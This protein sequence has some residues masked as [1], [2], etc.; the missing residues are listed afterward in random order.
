MSHNGTLSRVEPARLP[1]RRRA[2]ALVGRDLELGLIAAF[3]DRAAAEGGA[4]L[5]SGEPGV[6]KTALLDAAVSAALA[7]GAVVLRADG[8]DDET[9]IG[10][11][12][13][14]QALQPLR[15]ELESLSA[16]HRDALRAPLG[17]GDGPAP[18]RLVVSTAVLALLRQAGAAQPLLVVLDDLPW[19]DRAS[20]AVLGFAARRLAGSRVG[21]LAAARPGAE[22][23][24]APGGLPGH[25]VLPLDDRAAASLVRARFPGL[26]ASVRERVLAEAQGNPLALLELPAALSGRQRR[27]AAAL[28][29]VLP[30]S[31]RLWALFAPPVSDLPA[32]T[33]YLLLLAVLEGTGDLRLLQ[34]AAA[35]QPKIKALAPAERARLVHVDEGTG[36]LAFRHPL[37]R[38]A[39]VEL[40]AID[41]RRRAHRA[42]AEHLG[43]FPE[44]QARHLAE[45]AIRPDEQVADLLEQAAVRTLRRGDAVGA[46]AALQRSAE[47]SP[48]RHDGGRRLARAAYVG[49]DVTGDL[50]RAPRLL[51]SARQAGPEP[52]GSLYAAAATAQVL[53]HQDGDVDTAHRLLAGAV[54]AG[55]S[56]YA[57]GD[58]SLIDALHTLLVVC[59]SGGRPE[60]WEPFDVVI[61]RLAPRV[62]AVLHLCAGI[63]ADPARADARA[64]GRL[65]TAIGSLCDLTDPVWIVRIGMA[66]AYVD[67]LPGCREALWRVVRDGRQGGA[68]ASAIHAMIQLCLEDFRTGQWHE[69]EHLADEGLRLCAAHG[70]QFLAWFFR[71]GQALLAAARGDGDA[72]Q[73]LADEMTRWAAPRRAGVVQHYASHARALAALGRGDFEE[74]YQHAAAI[75]PAGRLRSHVPHALAA[76]MDLVEA[77]VRTG[78][79]A[80]AAAH[81]AAVEDAGIAAISPRLALLA[82]GS[83]ALAAPDR[84]AALFEKAVTIPGADRWPFDLA[85]VHLAYGEHLRRARVTSTARV[86]LS[87]ALTTFQRLGAG[88]W[89]VRAGHELR[90]AGQAASQICGAGSASLTPQELQIARLAAVGL[91][92]RQIG[93]RLLLSHRTVGAHLYQVFPKLGIVSRVEL[94]AALE[95]PR[96]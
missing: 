85:R 68:V 41:Q 87:A 70:Y 20:A 46:V 39:V 19:L 21:L 51:A 18:D 91:T 65:D 50:S 2:A 34:A 82:A 62:P 24:V 29:R 95:P 96:S 1:R 58:D 27:A 84:A 71:Y 8:V 54:D 55:A 10:F 78:R 38:S 90:A 93:E 92:N 11:S 83:A 81:V 16:P 94:R 9:D 74:A 25:E 42:L 61:A 53:L 63:F 73:A 80:E 35:G 67:R 7:G 47:L 56:R 48:Q 77:A 13:L 52:G 5:L 14:N 49:A 17:L 31:R 3:L 30:L 28:P 59:W 40:S 64:L 37:T 69:A 76:V 12:G 60:L 32:P 43:D 22:G 6:G 79:D 66:A 23:G 33:R 86:H 44:R 4:L 36:R 88:P 26:A 72:A 57:A 15:G 75:S 89:A 45:A